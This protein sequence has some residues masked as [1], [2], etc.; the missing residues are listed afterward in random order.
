MPLHDIYATIGK[1]FYQ[2]KEHYMAM[3]TISSK[4]QIVVPAKVRKAAGIELGDKLIVDFN[5]EA[6]EVRIRK[7]EG[8]EAL[9]ERFTGYLPKGKAPLMDPGAYYA[10]REEAH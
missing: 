8:I 3:V 10:S 9:A 7:A 5:D 1:A 2:G 4:G 6:G